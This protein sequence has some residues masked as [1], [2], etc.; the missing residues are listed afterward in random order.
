MALSLVFAAAVIVLIR[1][2]FAGTPAEMR[3][4][5][6]VLSQCKLQA[7]SPWYENRDMLRPFANKY[8]MLVGGYMR[9]MAQ[10][11]PYR[12]E[13]RQY[14]MWMTST[15]KE[16]RMTATIK[17]DKPRHGMREF[18]FLQIHNKKRP[19]LRIAWVA[20][21]RKNGREWRNW[22][23]AIVR[24]GRNVYDYP[25]CQKPNGNFDAEIKVKAG[26]LL[27]A[28]HGKNLLNLDVSHSKRKQYFKAGV[29]IQHG[30]ANAHVDFKRL[31]MYDGETGLYSSRSG[32]LQHQG[33]PGSDPFCM[34]G[35]RLGTEVCCPLSCGKCGGRNCSDR[36]PNKSCC[37]SGIK[38][39]R[40]KCK[41]N[42]PP[43]VL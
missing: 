33:V 42:S 31:N 34:T 3:M 22:L 29:Y 39:S 38:R 14:D 2:A 20:Y 32:V 28:I 1:M 19:L 4:F 8:F 27:V 18:T 11:R 13:L 36:G 17:I 7:P 24:R 43:C 16:R 37:S 25:L 10:S 15:K 40:R 9:F 23:W 21:N 35:I 5:R 12:S 6:P 30:R 41:Y 26:R